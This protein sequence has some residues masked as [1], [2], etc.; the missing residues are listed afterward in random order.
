[1]NNYFN[2]WK[3][4]FVYNG[5]SRRRELWNFFLINNLVAIAI[6]AFEHW[7]GMADEQLGFGIVSFTFLLLSIFP[8]VSLLVRRIQDTGTSG[9]GVMFALIP[10]IGQL[11]LIMMIV[12]D[13]EEG[14]NQYG[15]DPRANDP[16]TS[17]HAKEDGTADDAEEWKP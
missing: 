6:L 1:M 11:I 3:K 5:R 14:P 15:P 16:E 2:C 8:W 9:S 4:T 17:H 7:F 13:G 10:V 12:S